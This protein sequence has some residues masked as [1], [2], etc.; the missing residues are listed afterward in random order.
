MR[1]NLY[2]LLF[3]YISHFD[4]FHNKNGPFI[5][6]KVDENFPALNKGRLGWKYISFTVLHSP[7]VKL[8][9]L[10][11]TLTSNLQ[12]TKNPSLI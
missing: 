11:L 2:G 6:I 12:L 1:I 7:R 5:L 10:N 8:V 3:L 9:G 4:Y